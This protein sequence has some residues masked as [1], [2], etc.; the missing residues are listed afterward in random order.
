MT[1]VLTP[2]YTGWSL[3]VRRK[4]TANPPFTLKEDV[5]LV[6]KSS[7]FSQPGTRDIRKNGPGWRRSLGVSDVGLGYSLTQRKFHFRGD[8]CS[9]TYILSPTDPYGP[10]VGSLALDGYVA[11]V[12]GVLSDPNTIS[13]SNA[14]IQ[15]KGRAIQQ[16]KDICNAFQGGTFLGELRETIGMIRRPAMA[17]RHGLDSYYR[18]AKKLSESG[19]INHVNKAIAGSWLEYQYGWRPLIG[20]L[21]DACKA[22][23]GFGRHFVTNRF[24]SVASTKSTAIVLKSYTVPSH[25]ATWSWE[26]QIESEAQVSY[27]GSVRAGNVNS[28]P[29]LERTWGLSTRDFLPTVWELIPYSFLVDY[30]SNVGSIIDCLSYCSGNLAW[31]NKSTKRRGNAIAKGLK[32]LTPEPGTVNSVTIPGCSSAEW[33]TFARNILDPTLNNI[34][35]PLAFKL[36]GSGTQFLNIGALATMRIATY[37]FKR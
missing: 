30:F 11:D 22:A 31:L 20:D 23:A 33:T 8:V 6:D 35:P 19:K 13:S 16:I 7:A 21:E 12:S 14:D 1:V 28:A 17:L 3:K 9:L 4:R 24:S 26:V 27:S 25:A 36:P 34:M 29:G 15:A 32:L 18:R 2:Q 10:G 5:L 37:R